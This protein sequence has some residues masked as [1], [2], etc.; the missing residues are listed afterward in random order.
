MTSRFT[1]L[2]DPRFA[3]LS[4]HLAER[5]N[6]AANALTPDNFPDVLDPLIRRILVDAFTTAQAQGGAI[7]V[8]DAEEQHLIPV[9]S[10]G[11][12]ADHLGGRF[13]QPLDRGLISLVYKKGQSIA[14]HDV[15]R[16]RQQDK[17]LDG[18]LGVLTCAMIAVP[19]SFAKRLRGVVSC[20]RLKPA[21]SLEPDPPGFSPDDLDDIER[22]SATLTRLL[23]HELV[24][25]TVGWQSTRRRR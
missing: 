19:L 15:Y 17:T 3:A 6:D 7:W 24:G 2:P 9:Y 1:L 25:A 21:Q 13:R 5:V 16:N 20:V 22:L 14:E 23:D 4:A 18:V 8:A 12:L 11:P 10:T